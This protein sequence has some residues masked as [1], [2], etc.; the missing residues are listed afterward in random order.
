M[1]SIGGIKTITDIGNLTIPVRQNV[2]IRLIVCDG[3]I[4]MRVEPLEA[5]R[6]CGSLI[7]WLFE[8]SQ[9]CSMCFII[10]LSLF[11]ITAPAFDLLRMASARP[12]AP[13][14]FKNVRK[15]F[16]LRVAKPLR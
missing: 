11:V 13:K 8:E 9:E 16:P 12:S 2:G 15:S 14:S 6:N 3:A 4:L 5:D 10:S 7:L 1:N